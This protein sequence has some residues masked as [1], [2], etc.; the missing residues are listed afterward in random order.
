MLGAW[1][2]VNYSYELLLGLLYK[3]TMIIYLLFIQHSGYTVHGSWNL[4]TGG[5]DP[6]VQNKSASEWVLICLHWLW[7]CSRFHLAILYT[8]NI[9]LYLSY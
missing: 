7:S 5:L 4:N 2:P 8:E 1:I 6:S 9:F 3:L